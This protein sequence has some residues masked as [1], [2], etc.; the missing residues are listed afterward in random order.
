[1]R[2]KAELI[3]VDEMSLTVRLKSQYF[4]LKCRSGFPEEI[5][6]A[7]VI[8]FEMNESQRQYT[9]A[10]NFSF[11][12]DKY[13]YSLGIDGIYYCQ[14]VEV[15][16]KGWNLHR[17]QRELRKMIGERIGFSGLLRALILGEKGEYEGYGRMKE[18]GISHLL[19]IS[20]LHFSII[21]AMVSKM[22]N[23]FGNRYVKSGC[24]VLVMALL[25]LIVR[26][27]YSAQRA[28]FTMLYSE[29]AQL[30]D[31]RV[32]LLSC[33]SF[34]IVTMLAF[35]P[36]AILSTG[37]YLSYYTYFSVAFLYRKIFPKRPGV[38]GNTLREMLKFS[39]FLQCI[40]LPIS[41]RLFGTVNLY[42]FL[43]NAL[44]VPLFGL[45][46][47]FAFFVLLFAGAAPVREIWHLLETFFDHLV[48]IAPY[49]R[50][51]IHLT[52]FSLFVLT[53]FLF[54][55]RYVFSFPC[56]HKLYSALLILILFLPT[57]APQ[58]R[59]VSIDVG[60]GDST[61]IISEGIRILIDTGDGKTDIASELRFHGVTELDAVIITHAHK[62]HYGGLEK[63]LSRI[64]VNHLFATD[65][66][67]KRLPRSYPEGL[68]IR[69]VEEDGSYRL[70]KSGKSLLLHLYRLKSED[71][72]NNNGI[73]AFLQAA[74]RQLFFFGDASEG[75]MD[76]VMDRH[77]PASTDLYFLKAPHHG[78]D[79][80]AGSSVF[81][82]FL[83][84]YLS[85]SHSHKYHLPAERFFKTAEGELYSTYYNGCHVFEDG[86]V[87]SYFG[88][89]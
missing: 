20:G 51:P 54:L 12:Y 16:E 31:K 44:C 7:T 52:G 17:L 56:R 73:C 19:V 39:F 29:A 57:P 81:D 86:E 30:R 45:M 18:L 62:D 25:L 43:A 47:P 60:H 4:L 88:E 87:R 64:R 69:I 82:R 15:I 11:D 21:G 48:S 63:L 68:R 58:L 85:V 71:D 5:E 24:T 1:M 84:R 55:L 36:R 70:Q 23:V 74:G 14:S 22:M 89:R 26:G 59:I 32:D 67:R 33:Q 34:S 8:A 42:S 38:R 53:V 6:E 10:K 49:S 9:A 72:E 78:S 65:E 80:S 66:T 40:T 2:V 27:S 3:H 35:E 79:T 76:E 28:F 75:E 41:S 37:V 13:L 61:L 50:I 46:V 77:L 83:V